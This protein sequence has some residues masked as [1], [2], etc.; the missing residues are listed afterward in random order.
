MSLVDLVVGIVVVT[1]LV[2]VMVGVVTYVA[3]KLRMAREPA[4]PWDEEETR[5]FVR[6]EPG[7]LGASGEPAGG[8]AAVADEDGAGG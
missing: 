4:S 6:Y 2:T 7:D 5:Y 8:G 3:Y 1:I